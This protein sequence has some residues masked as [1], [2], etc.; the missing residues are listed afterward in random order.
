MSKQLHDIVMPI[1]RCQVCCGFIA[2]SF[3]VRVC[4]MFN[5]E[6]ADIK[7]PLFRCE[8]EWEVSLAVGYIN[9]APMLQSG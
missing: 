8:H 2:R 5:Q 6:F 3:S 1:Y 4:T 9:E 7:V